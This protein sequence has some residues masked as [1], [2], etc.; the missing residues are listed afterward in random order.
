M[1]LMN[2]F[3]GD[4][5]PSRKRHWLRHS[6]EHE[7][8]VYPKADYRDRLVHSDTVFSG[9]R[10]KPGEVIGLNMMDVKTEVVCFLA[11]IGFDTATTIV[12]PQHH[13][14]VS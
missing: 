4:E 2:S 11:H 1:L 9:F 5:N 3:L 14:R 6:M 7:F 8:L 13:R 12:T 10:L